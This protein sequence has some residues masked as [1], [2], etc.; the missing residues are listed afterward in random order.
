MSALDL[1]GVDPARR[2]GIALDH[3]HAARLQHQREHRMPRALSAREALT[4]LRFETL[5][6]WVAAH[7]VINDVPMTEA[8]LE[9]LTVACKR[10]DAIAEEAA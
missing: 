2:S 1:Q 9:R 5:L 6:V 7:N 4:A 8:D 3:I 10:I